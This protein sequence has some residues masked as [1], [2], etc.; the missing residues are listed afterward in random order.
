MAVF[1]WT[2]RMTVGVARFD[3]EH[4]TLIAVG[5]RLV[6]ALQANRDRQDIAVV[7]DE[8]VADTLSHCANEE[9]ALQQT[10]YPYFDRHREEHQALNRQVLE[11]QRKYQAGSGPVLSLD[12]M[13]FLKFWLANHIQATDT[14][15]GPYLNG[16]GQH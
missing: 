15:Y 2:Q 12:V 14:L 6:E 8:L 5:N 10:A 11:I 3:D 7:V 9:A 16:E 13:N 1:E 4:R